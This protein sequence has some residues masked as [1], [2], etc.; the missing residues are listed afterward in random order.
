MKS[1]IDYIY[2]FDILK[3]LKRREVRFILFQ[4]NVPY[5]HPLKTPETRSFSMLSESKE[6]DQWHEMG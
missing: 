6:R 2:G 4:V 5:L 1:F 3:S